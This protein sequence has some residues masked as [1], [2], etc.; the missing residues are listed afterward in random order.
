MG[1]NGSLL[2][3]LTNNKAYYGYP[4]A[5]DHVAG[6]NEQTTLKLF[7]SRYRGSLI[8]PVTGEYRFWV[9]GNGGGV[10]LWLADGTIVEP[11][12]SN[13][14][15]NRFGK[16]FLATSSYVTPY[17]D[18]DYSPNQRS[19]VINL[20][21]GQEYYLEVIQAVQN[22][23]NSH[24]QV[25][26]EYPGQSRQIIPDLQFLSNVEDDAD[27]DNDNL[28]DA[29]ETTVGLDPAENGYNDL[30]ESEYG[31]PD[32][33]NLTN[34]Q[35]YQNGTDPNNADSDGDGYS[36]SEELN[37]YGSDPLT[38]NNLAPVAVTFP[39]AQ[40][41]TSATGSWT[42]DSTGAL[43]AN[44]RRGALT[45]TFSVTQAGVHEVEIE[46]SAIW[47]QS[48]YTKQ[49]NLELTLNDDTTPFAV[50]S[51]SSNSTSTGTLSAI[52]PWL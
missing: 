49:L 35:E 44:D 47:Y 1:I 46:A 23:K 34:L 27:L 41:Y 7:G 17:N 36:D 15:T 12:T 52:T 5:I 2:T 4:N 45:Y 14:L 51:L 3:N 21:Q 40:T 50:G 32:A 33:D 10:E 31:D 25:A 11:G 16:R 48:W 26:W 29:W 39:D 30:D 6:V 13:P 20:T 42:P 8:A 38:S 18:F 28:P 19:V 22:G 37:Y 24:A 9:S 43:V